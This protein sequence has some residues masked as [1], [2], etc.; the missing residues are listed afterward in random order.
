MGGMGMQLTERDYKIFEFLTIA[1]ST[2]NIISD[3]LN[4]ST[5]VIRRRLQ[6]LFENEYV[7]RYR[8]DINSH[9]IY[10]VDQRQPRD[11]GHQLMLSK[12]YVYFTQKGYQI[13]KFKREMTLCKGIR[14]DGLAVL[15][16]GAELEIMVVEVEIWTSPSEKV[17]K[18]TNNK[19]Q[20]IELFGVVPK[21]LFITNKQVKS[22]EFEI[23]VLKLDFYENNPK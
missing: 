18:Y 6:K 13:F 19:D 8:Q 5:Q 7:K 15:K 22:K 14:A 2:S 16:R 9:Y 3:Y 21:L 17:K 20:L 10:Y 1:P 23:E 12:L 11:L 4:C